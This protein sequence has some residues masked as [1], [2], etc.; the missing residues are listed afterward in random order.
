MR[1]E[2]AG[3]GAL[4]QALRQ[5]LGRAVGWALTDGDARPDW[6]VLCAPRG[7][8]ADQL[9]A[10]AARGGGLLCVP[11]AAWDGE[12]ARKLAELAAGGQAKALRPECFQPWIA[13]LREAL[14]GEWLGA[15]GTVELVRKRPLA[16][17]DVLDALSQ[18][19]MEEA[20]TALYLLGRPRRLFCTV[21]DL[22]QAGQQASLT[23][24]LAGGTLVNIQAAQGGT[25]APYF[26]YEYAGRYGLAEYDSRQG[27]LRW[28]GNGAV[29]EPWDEQVC[30]RAMEQA[31]Q[32]PDDNGLTDL[33]RLTAAARQSAARRQVVDWEEAQM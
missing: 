10:W 3:G 4:A 25:D 6:V 5:A 17:G 30:I 26:R 2:V 29:Q 15:V 8:P 28:N 1:I 13:G 32:S 14:A 19:G 16:S 12:A 22:G 20:S 24:Q 18:C 33:L 27:A 21:A 31:L 23:M 7:I 11:Y 9:E